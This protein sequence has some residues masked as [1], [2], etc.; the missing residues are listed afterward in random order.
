MVIHKIKPCYDYCAEL[1]RKAQFKKILIYGWAPKWS[2]GILSIESNKNI[3]FLC[4]EYERE[5]RKIAVSS[6]SAWKVHNL[7]LHM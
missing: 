6:G 3:T 1:N 2:N 7:N 5:I 4:V